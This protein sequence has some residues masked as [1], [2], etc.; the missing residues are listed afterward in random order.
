M[1]RN[2]NKKKTERNKYVGDHHI[3]N[4]NGEEMEIESTADPKSSF[5]FCLLLDKIPYNMFAVADAECKYFKL[6]VSS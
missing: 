2:R 5:L 1:A 4:V 3:S 6:K